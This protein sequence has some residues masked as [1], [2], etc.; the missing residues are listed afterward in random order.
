[1]ASQLRHGKILNGNNVAYDN[2]PHCRVTHSSDYR[3][4]G[5]CWRA[6]PSPK[7]VNNNNNN[8]NNNADDF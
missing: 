2:T 3:T 4:N 6:N 7:S 1:M 8:N 5:L